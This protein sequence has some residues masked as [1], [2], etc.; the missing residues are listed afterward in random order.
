MGQ[1]NPQLKLY[2]AQFNNEKFTSEN[3]LAKAYLS[4]AE[5]LSPVVTFLY[6]GN[7]SYQA[8]NFPILFATEGRNQVAKKEIGSADLTYRVRVLGRPRKA[9]TIAKSPYSDGD[10]PGYGYTRFILYFEDRLFYKSQSLLTSSRQEIRVLSEP[11]QEGKF[12]R[13]E[14][15]LI[16]NNPKAYVHPSVISVGKK[17]SGSVAKVSKSRSRGVESRSYTPYAIQNQLSVIRESYNIAG[18]MANKV[19]VVEIS[20]PG[21]SPMKYWVQWEMF[22]KDLQFREKLDAD[23][24]YSQ[25]NMDKDGIIHNID[26]DTGEVIPSSAGML[27]QIDNEDT[28]GLK[29]TANKLRTLVT[30]IFYNA[31]GAENIEVDVYTG[32]GGMTDV[33][34]AMEDLAKEFSLDQSVVMEKGKNNKYTYTGPYFNSYITREG[35]RLNFKYH[36]SMDRGPMA[37]ASEAHPRTGY[38]KEGYNMY[39]VDMSTYDGQ[40]NVQYV[41]EKGRVEIKKYIQGMAKLPEGDDSM[42]ASTDIDASSI[43]IMR[44]QG[45]HIHRPGNCFKLYLEA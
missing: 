42:Y 4:E 12:W 11:K 36:P 15:Q 41:S 6:G 9:S 29:L 3:H 27:Q 45:V 28:R 38:K 43:Q 1:I 37:E 34:I 20:V 17:L 32:T 26:E 31:S 25:Y 33:S 16:T 2:S 44:T 7:E 10:K 30:D 39:C 23:L 21:Q 22:L 35:N 19:M 40:Q 24:L 5:W 8:F 14:C 18:N 13:Y